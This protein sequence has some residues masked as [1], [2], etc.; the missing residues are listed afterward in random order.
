VARFACIRT[1]LLLRSWCGHC[2]SLAPEWKK[3]AKL[4]KGVAKVVAVDASSDNSL[5]GRFGVKGF[6]TIKIFGANKNKPTDYNGQRTSSAIVSTVMKEVAAL[7]SSR[8][9]P[10]ASSSS[11]GSSKSS[12]GRGNSDPSQ[13]G[14]GKDVVTLTAANFDA[15]VLNSE[16][17]WMVEFYAP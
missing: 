2:K 15:L 4:L 8:G 14:G 3:A 9:G 10:K 7:V 17:A 13:P 11:S 16:E 6:P 5:A 12:G 1:T